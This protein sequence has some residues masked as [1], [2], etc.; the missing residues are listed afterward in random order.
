VYKTSHRTADIAQNITREGDNFLFVQA[1][2]ATILSPKI[3]EDTRRRRILAMPTKKLDRAI[4][5]IDQQSVEG[6][7]GRGSENVVRRID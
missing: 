3:R 5:Q 6:S 7:H 4:S 1:G 2:V